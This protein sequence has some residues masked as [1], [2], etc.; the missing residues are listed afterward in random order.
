MI[1]FRS[2]IFAR[3]AAAALSDPNR[4]SFR[5]ARVSRIATPD[6]TGTSL[7]GVEVVYEGTPSTLN[8]RALTQAALTGLLKPILAEVNMV[9]APV[10]D[11]TSA[12][13][14]QSG[15]QGRQAR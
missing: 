14:P 2:E 10:I 13:S 15:A 1:P 3:C 6:F 12:K 11:R 4:T 9:N 8:T 7:A 5:S